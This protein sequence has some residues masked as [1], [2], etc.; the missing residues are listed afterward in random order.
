MS[1]ASGCSCYQVVAMEPSNEPVLRVNYTQTALVLGGS[2]P[3][4]VPPDLL[5]GASK[6]LTPLQGDTVKMIAS[7][8]TP[9]VCPSALASKLRVAV[10]LYGLAGVLLLIYYFLLLIATIIVIA[11][12]II[13]CCYSHWLDVSKHVIG[14]NGW[15]NNVIV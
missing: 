13:S 2:V 9:L 14:L 7:I 8:L 5:I 11:L 1:S 15:D 6:G 4:A 3:S 10:L 12:A